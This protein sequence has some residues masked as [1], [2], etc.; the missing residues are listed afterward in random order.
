MVALFACWYSWNAVVYTW[1][2]G[3]KSIACYCLHHVRI[4][5]V[6]CIKTS[7]TTHECTQGIETLL[8]I[9]E[10]VCWLGSEIAM[11]WITGTEVEFKSFFQNQ[12]TETWHSLRVSHGRCKHVQVV[13]VQLVPWGRRAEIMSPLEKLN[14][15]EVPNE[16]QDGGYRENAFLTAQTTIRYVSDAQETICG[17][18]TLS[19]HS[20]LLFEEMFL[21]IGIF[22]FI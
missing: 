21:N 7:K 12:V 20:M 17:D 19:D 16:H 18:W 6:V 4:K 8:K 14:P 9:S 5:T 10:S 13:I 15:V 1:Y 2:L 22:E 11:T 3:N